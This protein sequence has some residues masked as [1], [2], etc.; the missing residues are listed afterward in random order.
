MIGFIGT[1]IAIS[2]NYNSSQSVTIYDSLHSLLDYE[3]L[4]FHCDEWWAK[5]HSLLPYECAMIELSW[6]ELTCRRPEC[7]SPPRT[8]RVILFV[9]SHETCLPNLCQ[10]MD[11]SVSIRYSGNVCFVSRWLAMDFRSG[12]TIPAF[13]RC[14]Q[15]RCLAIVTF[16]TV[17]CRTYDRWCNPIRKNH[18]GLCQVTVEAREE[19]ESHCQKRAQSDDR[20]D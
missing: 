13:R 17:Q 16:V 3:C 12:S 6:T 20:E 5:D 11:Y 15:N 8:V 9:H 18:K 7:R 1:A 2:I 14:L 19:E 10:A 4:L